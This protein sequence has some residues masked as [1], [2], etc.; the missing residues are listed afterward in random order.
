MQSTVNNC[1]ANDAGMVWE[2]FPWGDPK[3]AY[4]NDVCLTADTIVLS[5][6]MY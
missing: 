1:I 6:V 4:I 2:S 3:Q 5:R